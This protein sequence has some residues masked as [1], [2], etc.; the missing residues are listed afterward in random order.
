MKELLFYFEKE[1]DMGTTRRALCTVALSLCMSMG[2]LSRAQQM[3]QVFRIPAA[4]LQHQPTEGQ[5]Y[6][7]DGTYGLDC[8]EPIYGL[9]VSG[10]VELKD[11][12]NS[13]VR[14]TVE[15]RYGREFL[16]YEVFPLLTEELSFD[17]EGMAMESAVLD[18]IEAESLNIRI[19]N[20]SFRLDAV[21]HAQ[22]PVAN[23]QTAKQ[24]AAE[25][26]EDYIVA[27]LNENLQSRE[28]PWVAGRTSVSEMTY[29]E[30][31]AMF[32]GEVPNLGGFEYY[33]GGVFVMPGY[34]PQG[35]KAKSPY[36][37][38]WDWTARN[39][40]SWV[41]GPG[42]QGGCGA[43]WAFAAIGMLEVYVNLYYNQLI[44]EKLSEQELV[45]CANKTCGFSTIDK[46][47]DYIGDEGVVSEDCFP[48]RGSQVDCDNKCSAPAERVRISGYEEYRAVDCTE[49]KLKELLFR[50]PVSVTIHSWEHEAMVVGYK[51]ITAGLIWY[52]KGGRIYSIPS[53]SELIGSTAWRIRNSWGRNWGEQGFGYIVADWKD[54]E[55]ITAITGKIT[56][57]KYDDGDI[58]VT[59]GDGDGY[60]VWG[61]GPRPS[62]VPSWVPEQQDGDDEDKNKGPIDRY[63]YME[64]LN[65]ET[66]DPLFVR[67][68]LE[69]TTRG[70]VHCMVYV[71]PGGILRITNQITMHEKAKILVADGGKL[72]VDGG[73]VE[74][75]D[76]KVFSGGSL[77]LQNGGILRMEGFDVFESEPG[78]VMLLEEGSIE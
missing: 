27:K 62:K 38:Q 52:D 77:E 73:L 5:L 26:Q 55:V 31:K 78:A 39:G 56:S 11:G 71:Q 75:A 3:P 14:V 1:D 49:D 76:V 47:L 33:V 36:V 37:A 19:I 25:E 65:P 68:E 61:V 24:R 40:K 2:G 7:A 53:G 50:S 6:E 64:D 66:N 54:M 60:Y 20:A 59:D 21:Q 67:S 4:V 70:H 69:W 41:S 8:P 16:V 45:S 46:S 57:L 72:I 63:G 29:E 51:E 30:K 13:L 44:G 28:V 32:G 22:E 23:A 15:D 34:K 74:R 43:C 10:H 58:V 17:I 12:S 42:D 9:S 35:L 48:Y 18:G